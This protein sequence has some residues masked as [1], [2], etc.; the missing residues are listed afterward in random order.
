MYALNYRTVIGTCHTVYFKSRK[1]RKAFMQD[2]CT[3]LMVKNWVIPI[4]GGNDD[5][6]CALAEEITREG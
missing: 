2:A 1:E 6:L 3:L 5:Q 4:E